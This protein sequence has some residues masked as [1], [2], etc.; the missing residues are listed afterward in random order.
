VTIQANVRWV[1][2]LQFVGRS[3]DGPAVVID[4]TKGGSGASPMEL[5]LLGV[6][7]CTAID[8]V[9]IMEKKR[10]RLT[11]FDVNIVGQRAETEPLRYTAIEIEYVL[12]GENIKPKGVEQ[13]IALSEE[14]YCSALASLNASVTHSY[15]IES[16]VEASG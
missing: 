3:G 9:L 13:A 14:K 1:Q 6:A 16:A 12:A 15:R 4:S 11:R 2:D 5:V 7:G 8:V 10:A